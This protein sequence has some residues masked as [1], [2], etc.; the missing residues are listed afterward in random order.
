MRDSSAV[1]FGEVA[2]KYSKDHGSPGTD[3]HEENPGRNSSREVGKEEDGNS[4]VHQNRQYGSRHAPCHVLPP[5]LVWQR[6]RR[7]R[8]NR[9]SGPNAFR[10]EYCTSYSEQINFRHNFD[11]CGARQAL[12]PSSSKG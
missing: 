10:L 12:E 11:I 9:V 4:R 7:H 2:A 8:L 3:N 5:V 6:F 1:T